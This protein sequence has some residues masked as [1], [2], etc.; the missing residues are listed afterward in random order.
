MKWMIRIALF[1]S[2]AINGYFIFDEIRFNRN[3]D[4]GKALNKAIGGELSN[5]TWRQGLEIFKNKLKEKNSTLLNK[6]YY[7]INVWTNWCVPCIKEMPW[8]DSI[9]GS[10]SRNDIGYVFVSDISDDLANSC[11][12][13]KN[14]KMDNFVF[15]NDMSDFVSAICNEKG[16]KNK[17]YPMALVLSNKGELLHYSNGAYESVQE[18]SE[19]A[20]LITKLE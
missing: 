12:R 3:Q 4:F 17:I 1:I 16:T 13:R 5:T 9:A 2:V 15:L 8:L 10:L 11:L 7:Y 20:E 14:Y 18:A 6:K 19:F